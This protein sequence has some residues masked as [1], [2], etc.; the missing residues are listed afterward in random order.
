MRQA[1]FT[2]ALVGRS[3]FLL[4][5]REVAHTHGGGTGIFTQITQ[6][7]QQLKK[8]ELVTKLI[9]LAD[10]RRVLKAKGK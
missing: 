6:S 10:I 1:L 5:R 7:A 4:T 8:E 2:P 3:A 9:L